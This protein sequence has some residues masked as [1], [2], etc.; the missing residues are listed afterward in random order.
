MPTIAR[1]GGYQIEMHTGREHG[2][3]HVHVVH[4]GRDVLVNLLTLEPFGVEP[5]RLPRSVKTYIEKNQT[6]LLRLWDEYH[7]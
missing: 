5:F 3:P 2:L 1:I 4:G 6:E 7:G